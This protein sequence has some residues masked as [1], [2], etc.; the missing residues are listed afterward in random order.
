MHHQANVEPIKTSKR[1]GKWQPKE[2]DNPRKTKRARKYERNWSKD[3]SE[4]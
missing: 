1:K 2:K 4:M 3:N